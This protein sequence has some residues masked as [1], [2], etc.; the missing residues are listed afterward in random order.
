MH[1]PFLIFFHERPFNV[2]V[3]NL[4]VQKCKKWAHNMVRKIVGCLIVQLPI[5]Q[6]KRKFEI[7]FKL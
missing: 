4:E 2:P 6:Y 1:G 5:K 3:A 7:I